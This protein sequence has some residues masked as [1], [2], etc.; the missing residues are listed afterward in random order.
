MGLQCAYLIHL[1]PRI[2]RHGLNATARP[3]MAWRAGRTRL[4]SYLGGGVSVDDAFG[5]SR[6]SDKWASHAI[7][8]CRPFCSK[9]GKSFFTS[10]LRALI[11]TTRLSRHTVCVFACPAPHFSSRLSLTVFPA[12]SKY[13]NYKMVRAEN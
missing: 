10:T 8:L 12:L 4:L 9:H 13:A 1:Q 7:S 2:A 3:H 6:G 11:A 5:A